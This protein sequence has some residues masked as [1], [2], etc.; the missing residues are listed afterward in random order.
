MTRSDGIQFIYFIFIFFFI[1]G[2]V[3]GAIAAT[4]VCPLDVIKTRF[5]V[6]GLPK[7][8]NGSIKGMF[9][10]NHLTFPFF[11]VLILCFFL[12]VIGKV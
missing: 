5:Q 6:H 9:F 7:L 1:F 3:L 8:A 12:S 10:N 4:F 11:N 2:V